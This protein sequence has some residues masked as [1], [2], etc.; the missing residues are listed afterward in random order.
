MKWTV[1]IGCTKEIKNTYKIIGG[2][3]KGKTHLE[4]PEIDAS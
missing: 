2:K 1:H 3:I 4:D